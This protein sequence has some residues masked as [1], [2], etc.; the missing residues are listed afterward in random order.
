MFGTDSFSAER[1]AAGK[2][3]VSPAAA[4]HVTL[5]CLA[6]SNAKR[7]LDFAAQSPRRI[8]SCA[9]TRGLGILVGRFH[10]FLFKILLSSLFPFFD[11]IA[12]FAFTI[13]CNVSFGH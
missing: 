2:M 5:H 3:D 4:C 13:A 11:A 1:Q 6:W 7:K 9:G 10:I 12:A 8:V